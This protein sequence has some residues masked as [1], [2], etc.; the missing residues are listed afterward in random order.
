[1]ADDFPLVSY[2]KNLNEELNQGLLK[3]GFDMISIA[4]IEI[5]RAVR[6]SSKASKYPK[7]GS[8]G[9]GLAGSFEET[10]VADRRI[11]ASHQVTIGTYSPLPY[12]DIQD[13]GDKI[14]SKGPMLAIPLTSEAINTGSPFNW[15]ADALHWVPGKSRGNKKKSY[16]VDDQ[17]Q[18]QYALRNEVKIK[19]KNYISKAARRS[20]KKMEKLFLSYVEN[21]S[22]TA[23]AKIQVRAGSNWD[24]GSFYS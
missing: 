20:E 24:T 7:R 11:G 16:F 9:G 8:G 23:K 1:M 15:P 12:A 13:R 19:G 4:T 18:A 10:L 5:E 22:N 14:R 2:L 6:K 21:S 3:V 17:N